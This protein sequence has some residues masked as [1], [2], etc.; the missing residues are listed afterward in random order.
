MMRLFRYILG[1]IFILALLAADAYFGQEMFSRWFYLLL[2]SVFFAIVR[3]ASGKTNP[4]RALAFKAAG[5][6][7]TGFCVILSI[8]LKNDIYIE[9]AIAW[10]LQSFIATLFMGKYFGGEK[11][12][13]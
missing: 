7:L 11:T 13:D 2:A 8:D 1:F 12:N 10:V 6:A 9:I 4:D 5:M 3:L